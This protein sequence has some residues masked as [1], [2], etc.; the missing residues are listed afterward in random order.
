MEGFSGCKLCGMFG[1]DVS[2]HLCQG[3]RARQCLSS[4]ES[5]CSSTPAESTGRVSPEDATAPF[6]VPHTLRLGTLNVA[7]MRDVASLA[8]LVARHAPFDALALQEVEVADAVGLAG[9]AGRLGMRVA[10]LRRAD[11]GLG[12]AILV[13]SDSGAVDVGSWDLREPAA[14][15]NRSAVAVGL[16]CGAVVCC[17]HLD[18]YREATRLWQWRALEALLGDLGPSAGSATAELGTARTAVAGEEEATGAAGGAAALVVLGDFNALRRADYAAGDWGELVAR[19]R[20]NLIETRSALTEAMGAAGW[21]DARSGAARVEGPLPTS[22][23]GVRVDYAW[24]SAAAARRFLV[25]R[26]A[27]AP[28]AEGVTDHALVVCDVAERLP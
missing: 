12:N 6:D 18:A 16:P 14:G 4:H 1:V 25:A 21:R 19:R 2:D 3:C 17:T 8:A 24:L 23:H 13:P 22:V 7:R 5:T 9:L 28:A 27:H 11:F 26:V 15:E 20:H 10:T